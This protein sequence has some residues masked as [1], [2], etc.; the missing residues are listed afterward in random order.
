MAGRPRPWSGGGFGVRVRPDVTSGEAGAR[1]LLREER[2]PARQRL[3]VRQDIAGHGADAV[4]DPADEVPPTP[5]RQG[6]SIF[7][8]AARGVASR[9]SAR[10]SC[11]GRSG[12]P[13]TV[14]QVLEVGERMPGERDPPLLD[15]TG[16]LRGGPACQQLGVPVAAVAAEDEKETAGQWGDLLGR[17]LGDCWRPGRRPHHDGRGGPSAQEEC[18]GRKP[19]TIGSRLTRPS[20]RH[21][22]HSA[23]RGVIQ[24]AGSVETTRVRTTA[25]GTPASSTQSGP[26]VGGGRHAVLTA[27]VIPHRVVERET[28]E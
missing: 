8:N 13:L 16:Q 26:T 17:A 14:P 4:L 9:S 15:V 27:V 25:I 28:I 21:S 24:R 10:L 6:G 11:S 5:S 19:N 23:A 7:T 22:I 2:L 1:R 20:V 12:Y 3:R 18:G